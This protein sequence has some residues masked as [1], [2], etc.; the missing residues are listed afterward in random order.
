MKITRIFIIAIVFP[1]MLVV[2]AY[3]QKVELTGAG[4]TFPYPL[5]TKMFDAYF[6]NTGVKVNYQA[7]G[8]GAGITQL[9]NKTVDFG[10]TDAFMTEEELKQAGADILHIPIVLGSVV[11]TYNLPGNPKINLSPDVIADIFLGK[12][13]E[14]NDPRIAKDNPNI[15][16]PN[17]NI[18]V[19]R[20]SDGSGTTYIFS[21]YLSKV[22]QEWSKGPGRGK[23]LNW[24]TGL[25]AKGNPGVA[26][27][28]KQLPGS[29][30][31]VELIYAL[32]NNMPVASIKNK[33]GVFVYPSLQ[34]TSASAK[35]E[36]PPDTR[37]SITD[38][39]AKDGYPI[40]GFT[41]IVIYKEQKYGNRTKEKAEA[42]LNLLWWMTHEGQSLA[43]PLQYA[44]LPKDVVTKVEALL[45][46]ATYGGSKVLK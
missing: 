26:G 40:S 44:P 32:Q 17:L 35:A 27:L 8:S 7:V 19:V 13:T 12:I 45:K 5:Y 38:T 21:D 20:R 9:V 4:A 2:S 36:I 25:G 10:A 42:L 37:V 18:V 16:L 11:L 24:P 31:Y 43:E 46:S 33:S 28:V 22:S 23:S 34:A 30:G 41:W 1:L 6:K 14:W 3:A 15:K 39:P 29:I